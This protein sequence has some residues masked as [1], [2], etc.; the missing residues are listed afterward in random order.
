M[1]KMAVIVASLC[2]LLACSTTGMAQTI[3]SLRDAVTLTES[4]RALQDAVL[5]AAGLRILSHYGLSSDRHLKPFK[6][7]LQALPN[8]KLLASNLFDKSSRT[9]FKQRVAGRLFA[10]RIIEKMSVHTR[11][12][13]FVPHKEAYVAIIPVE[14]AH[15][16]WLDLR[17]RNVEGQIVCGR[18]PVRSASRI[19]NWPV[20]QQGNMT[21]EIIN[22]SSMDISYILAVD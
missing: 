8:G 2:S 22:R 6:Q 19:C 7:E 10:N 14:P 12:E 4:G 13:K 15:S 18:K 21:I 17:I 3:P 9:A 11:A 16:K 1:T 20:G 5:L